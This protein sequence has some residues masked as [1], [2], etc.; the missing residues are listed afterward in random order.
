MRMFEA[1]ANE[2]ND[3]AENTI[4]IKPIGSALIADAEG[5]IVSQSSLER[6]QKEWRVVADEV[7]DACREI[8]GDNLHS[9]YARGSVSQGKA[10]ENV[11]DLDLI[12][13]VRE[14]PTDE[15]W[16]AMRQE[17]EQA[18]EAYPFCTKVEI[19]FHLLSEVISSEDGVAN[20]LK[21]Y[22]VCVYGSDLI[23]ELP[24]V[25][26]DRTASRGIFRF[27]AQI[28]RR[29]Q[30]FE[31]KEAVYSKKW[32]TWMMKRILRVG[33]A[34]V[35]EREQIYTRDLYPCY[36]IFAKYYPEHEA[37]MRRVLELA[38]NPTDAYKEVQDLTEDFS[39]WLSGE[40]ELVYGRSEP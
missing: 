12:M 28:K 22:S 19:D 32:C 5:Y 9:V 30:T 20:T 38:L 23:N 16:I 6:M 34:L 21:I 2:M 33:G 4:E 36:E 8:L 15:Q 37:Q 1:M 17:R 29:L 35:L 27:N 10:I 40:V 13:L 31:N 7:S 11:S 25:K 14:W 3:P 24:R 26:M 39:D 18:E